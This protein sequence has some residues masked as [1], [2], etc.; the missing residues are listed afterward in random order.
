MQSDP[1]VDV[2]RAA[3]PATEQKQNLAT[4]ENGPRGTPLITNIDVAAVPKT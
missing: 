2:H 3:G 4:D 1:S